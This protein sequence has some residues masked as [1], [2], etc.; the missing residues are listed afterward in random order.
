MIAAL[1]FGTLALV[2]TLIV[3]FRW[4]DIQ[5]ACDVLDATADF[6]ADTK[7]IILVQ[8]G[9][10]FFTLIIVIVWLFGIMGLLS[11][12]DVKADPTS[13]VP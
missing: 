6:F 7:R 13:S 10:F 5:M 2:F 3:C 1:F 4:N 9:F 8:V 11:I 12:A